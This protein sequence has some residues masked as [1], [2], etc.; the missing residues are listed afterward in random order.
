MRLHST[1]HR[2]PGAAMPIRDNSQSNSISITPHIARFFDVSYQMSNI[3][4]VRV[5]TTKS[6]HIA[7]VTL[8][9]CAGIALY[10]AFTKTTPEKQPMIFIIAVCLAIATLVCQLFIIRREYI[11]ILK[12][13]SGDIQAYKTTDKAQVFQIKVLIEDGFARRT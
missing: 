7:T 8:A 10:M 11:L 13:S 4:S 6:I 3:G 1:L 5:V 2:P 12:T 9:I